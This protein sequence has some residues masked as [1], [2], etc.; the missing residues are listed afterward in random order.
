MRRDECRVVKNRESRCGGE[1][2]GCEV[3]AF[4]NH[5]KTDML[6]KGQQA[7][8]INIFMVYLIAPSKLPG[9]K[10]NPCPM[11]CRNKS[12]STS[13]SKATSSNVP[14]RIIKSRTSDP[15]YRAYWVQCPHLSTH[16]LLRLGSLQ[17]GPIR[18]RCLVR[19]QVLLE[20]GSKA[21]ELDMSCRPGSVD[22]SC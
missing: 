11:S 7:H 19:R 22:F 1:D 18:I 15:T 13:L 21:Q 9:R 2:V 17:K 8:A 6:V 16:S 3:S 12:P 14:V 4:N 10:P 20:G 5:C